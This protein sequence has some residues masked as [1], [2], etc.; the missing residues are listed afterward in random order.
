V[1]DIYQKWPDIL[2]GILRGY[3]SVNPLTAEEKQAIFH[4]ICS[5]QMVFAAWLET[6]DGAEVNE[7]AKTHRDMLRFTAD[8]KD[9]ITKICAKIAD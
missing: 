2:E 7:L 4:V 6:Q 8:K 3:D 1:D 9:R 5:I